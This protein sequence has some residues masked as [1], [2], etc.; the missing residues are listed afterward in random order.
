MSPKEQADAVKLLKAVREYA[1]KVR[2]AN[3]SDVAALAG[4]FAELTEQIDLF[5]D[6]DELD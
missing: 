6:H 4:E 1:N 2:H 5:L 3:P